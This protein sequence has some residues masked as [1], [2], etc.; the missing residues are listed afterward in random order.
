V[1]I[2]SS[3]RALE[4]LAGPALAHPDTA[5]KMSVQQSTPIREAITDMRTIFIKPGH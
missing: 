2:V 3:S 4:E 1:T 5:N